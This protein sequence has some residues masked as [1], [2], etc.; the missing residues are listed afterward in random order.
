MTTAKDGPHVKQ[1]ALQVPVHLN[2]ADY[3]L[4]RVREAGRSDKPALL[5]DDGLLT[6]AELE[7]TVNRFGNALLDLGIA[8]GDRVVVRAPNSLETVAATMAL[9]KIGAVPVPLSTLLGQSEVGYIL[10]DSGAVAF[11]GAPG[12]FLPASAREAGGLRR[13][14]ALWG[15]GGD[16]APGPSLSAMAA[17]HSTHL[18][19]APTRSLDQAFVLYSTGTT[20]LPKGIVH[21]HQFIVG[22][23][24]VM[25]RLWMNLKPG[26]VVLHPHE[27]SFSY[28]WAAGFW[29]PLYCGVPFVVYSARFEPRS[30]F[31][32]LQKHAV[33]SFCTVPTGYRMLLA[34]SDRPGSLPALRRCISAGEPLPEDV[35]RRWQQEFHVPIFDGIGTSETFLFCAQSSDH[36]LVHG[37]MGRPLPGYEVEIHDADGAPCPAGVVGNLAMREGH[38]SMFTEYLNLPEKWQETHRDGWFYGGDHAYMDAQGY[39]WHVSRSDDI[40]KSRGYFISPREVEETLLAHPAVQDAGVIGAADDVIGQRV[41]AYVS[42][43]EGVEPGEDLARQLREWVR[44]RIA[45]FK[46]PKEICFLEGG[47]PR[48]GSGKLLR[49]QLREL[50]E[51]GKDTDAANGLTQAGSFR[52]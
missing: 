7:L 51:T 47:L 18:E 3:V 37:S 29:V 41:K 32:H 1:D 21:G 13:V 42:L 25:G 8:R 11:L 15:E 31:D 43:R 50:H 27:L 20:G 39:V 46:A 4:Q 26:D 19:A 14:V 44:G 12:T 28:T 45:L 34:H 2:M 17:Q 38:P 33:T 36:A 40:I 48:T 24:E 6:F 23:G 9:I 52:F 49:R 10:S 5:F 16:D 22:V 30:L 35:S